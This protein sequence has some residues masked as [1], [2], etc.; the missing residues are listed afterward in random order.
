M[1]LEISVGVQRRVK[2]ESSL[3][4]KVEFCGQR[5]DEPRLQVVSV[6]KWWG[7]HK[8]GRMAWVPRLGVSWEHCPGSRGKPVDGWSIMGLRSQEK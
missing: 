1:Y 4:N 7:I 2:S 3:E 6:G 5:R 8:A